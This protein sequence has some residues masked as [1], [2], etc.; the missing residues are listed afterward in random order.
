M[1]KNPDISNKKKVHLT[2]TERAAEIVRYGIEQQK[3]FTN[4]L[5]NGFS[6]DELSTLR[7]YFNR[8]EK[9]LCNYEKIK[10]EQR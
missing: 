7:T 2:I 4:V 6:E 10:M 5:L 9:N 1:K 3:E 8:M